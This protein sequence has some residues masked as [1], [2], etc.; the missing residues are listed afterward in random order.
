MVLRVENFKGLATRVRQL[1][2]D[3][4]FGRY[5]SERKREKVRENI[6]TKERDSDKVRE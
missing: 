6:R 5:I 4:N 2:K 3:F 1:R